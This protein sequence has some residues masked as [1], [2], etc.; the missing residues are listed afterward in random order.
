M[1]NAPLLPIWL[2][3]AAQRFGLGP[4]QP[5]L[6]ASLEIACVAASS[7]LWASRRHVAGR[8]A[9]LTAAILV[10]IAANL[11]SLTA[12]QIVVL[13]VAR[14]AAGLALGLILAEITRRAATMPDPQRVFARQQLGLILFVATFFAT[15]P[16]TVAAYGAFVPFAYGAVLGLVALVS[17][18]WLPAADAKQDTPM[19]RAADTAAVRNGGAAAMALTAI[20]L[21]YLTQNGVWAYIAEAAKGS[22]TDLP[23]M[24]RVL[25]IGAF[26]NLLAPIIAERFGDGRDRRVPLALGY[27][28]L[29]VSVLL[30]T[31][32]LGQAEFI[33]G[34]IGLN[35][36]LMFVTPFLLG[37]LAELDS[38]GRTAAAG[39]AFFTIGAAIG[40]ALGG[41]L[42]ATGGIP[43]LGVVLAAF[44]AAALL[45]CYVATARLRRPLTRLEA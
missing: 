7:I 21:T 26:V 3:G 16:M 29:A 32:G 34:A 41:V 8:A 14:A 36:C 12:Q 15:V 24:G 45:L 4:A 11:L 37:I 42:I 23:L 28:G 43:S 27:A 2:P 44:A 22:G 20:A 17:L 10:S 39:P 25:A 19:H 35:L 38:S 40:P 18:I 33:V 1:S 6:I 9:R 30:I 5:G 31:L 13:V